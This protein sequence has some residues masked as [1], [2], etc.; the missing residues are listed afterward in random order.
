MSDGEETVT[1][2]YIYCVTRTPA[3]EDLAIG[4]IDGLAVSMVAV[5]GLAVVCSPSEG[6]RYRL[7]RQ[8]TLAHEL[9][10]ERA[11][12]FGTVLPVRFGTVAENEALIRKKLLAQRRVELHELLEKMD[13]KVEMGVKVL[14]DADLVYAH[15]VEHD[16]DIRTLRDQ[17][18]NRPPNETHYERIK[19][20]QMV[21]RALAKRKVDD[22][23][24]I[25][26]QLQPYAVDSRRNDVYSELMVLN[27]SFLVDT[28]Q[29][30]ALEQAVHE[31]DV[32]FKG[33][34][35]IK[36]VGP[37]PPFNF[38]DLVISWR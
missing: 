8:H 38:V 22:A 20:G 19:L 17:L 31:I 6:K 37:L 11:M 29:E 14:F 27:A 28:A 3:V 34:T 16:A 35:T 24:W 18:T 33:V 2:R 7:S 5:N 12:E 23:D 10:I 21:E 1:G 15:I 36:Y 32:K 4:G 25:M 13:G 26:E 30:P 9:V